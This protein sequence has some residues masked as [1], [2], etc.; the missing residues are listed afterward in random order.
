MRKRLKTGN[1]QEDLGYYCVFYHF[2]WLWL[3]LIFC[4]LVCI[5]I[6]PWGFKGL[7]LI[8]PSIFPQIAEND[9]VPNFLA[10]ML[11]IIIGF[12][13]DV[14]IIRR[15]RILYDYVSIR[16]CLVEDLKEIVAVLLICRDEIT[17]ER[18]NLLY[19]KIEKYLSTIEWRSTLYNLPRFFKLQSNKG[20]FVILL[21]N[22]LGLFQDLKNY[23][24]ETEEKTKNYKIQQVVDICMVLLVCIDSNINLYK[25]KAVKII[26]DN[27]RSAKTE[28]KDDNESPKEMHFKHICEKSLELKLK[29]SEL[30]ECVKIVFNDEN[31]KAVEKI[32]TNIYKDNYNNSLAFKELE[33]D[34]E[35]IQNE[36]EEYND[37]PKESN[38]REFIKTSKESN[39]KL[40]DL[41]K[42][43]K[44]VFNK[45]D[46]KVV[47]RIC[48]K[49]YTEI[50]VKQKSVDYLKIN[51]I[52]KSIYFSVNS[53]YAK[54]SLIYCYCGYE[55]LDKSK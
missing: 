15:M 23:E 30:L 7:S 5:F 32:C 33:T 43:I 3:L 47:Q 51:E 36:I 46:S 18:C 12:I 49:L 53:T 26:T 50:D 35:S 48:K 44:V 19:K 54:D 20:Q 52:R 25:Q 21:G 39:L 10:G 11:G 42:E 6:F 38:F 31:F 29:C 9:F 40:S 41:L 28:I 34:L 37:S 4:T 8:H 2:L 13:F 45:N 27:L 55:P 24:K 22:V 1:V 17:S 16:H 14:I